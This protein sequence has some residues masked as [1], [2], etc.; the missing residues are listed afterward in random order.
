VRSWLAVA[1]GALLSACGGGAGQGTGPG[2]SETIAGRPLDGQVVDTATMLAVRD[3]RRSVAFYRDSLGFAVKL[4]RATI[5][6]L[7]RD[8][9]RL[10]LVTE[11]PPTADR[12]GVTLAPPPDPERTSVNLVLRVRDARRAHAELE[13]RGVLFLAPPT[14][15]PWGG[16]R[17]FTRDP[18]GYLIE[19][20][21]PP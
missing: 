9:L 2:A 5:A 13:R 16:L 20:E 7:E 21:Q 14:A 17:C 4:R 15:P 10:Y 1:C 11:S 19:I 18:D 8:G 6:L 3:L 12:P